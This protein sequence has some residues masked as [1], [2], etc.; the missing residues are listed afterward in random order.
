MAM[1]ET[2]I[3]I[4]R[5][6]ESVLGCTCEFQDAAHIDQAQ[7]SSSD[8]EALKGNAAALPQ[9]VESQTTDSFGFP[10]NFQGRFAGLAVVRGA[11]ETT[12]RKLIQLA[13]LMT[14]VLENG[15]QREDRKERLR[16]IEE[17]LFMINEKSNVIPLRPSRF[18]RVM[19]V[20]DSEFEIESTPSP[21]LTTP[22][23][24]Q[25]EESF[26]LS[27]IAIEVHQ[28]SKRWAF[29]SVED[30]PSDTLSTR[31]GIEELGG[32]TLFIRD[33]TKLTT[34]QQLKLAE[35]L[36]SQ[37]TE[38]MPHVLAGVNLDV[39]ELEQTG[40]LL[41]HLTGLFI[42]TRIDASTGKS[43]AQITRELIEASLQHIAE[44]TRESHAIGKH[45]V[46]FHMQYFNSTDLH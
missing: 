16:M 11:K 32:I 35:F 21:L 13:E 4:N 31:E 36:A 34:N 8:L 46:P 18:G 19:Q 37:P 25:V 42:V 30:L 28:M 20:T 17:R 2:M 7:W 41:S 40:K 10:I 14:M 12:P 15:L 44:S 24:M 45:F 38:D 22:L 29:I 3:R 1:T 9:Y 27:R 23:L 33:L 43:A 39:A 26:P 6:F 5:I